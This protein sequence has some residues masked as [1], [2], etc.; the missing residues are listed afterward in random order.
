V[1][2]R[3]QWAHTCSTSKKRREEAGGR[4]EEWGGREEGRM[5]YLYY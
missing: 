2:R 1:E 3:S 4:R 5:N